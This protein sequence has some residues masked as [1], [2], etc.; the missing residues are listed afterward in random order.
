M[1]IE[2]QQKGAFLKGAPYYQAMQIQ[3]PKNIQHNN[4]NVR[5]NSNGRAKSYN[6]AM[7]PPKW[8]NK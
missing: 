3:K 5:S 7:K 1:P 8:L 4:F 6:K 2:A